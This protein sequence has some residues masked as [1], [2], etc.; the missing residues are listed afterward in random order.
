MES[1]L[2]AISHM[3]KLKGG[4]G[5]L[6][7]NISSVLGIEPGTATAIYSGSKFG[8]V[9]FTKSLAVSLLKLSKTIR[10]YNLMIIS[11]T[12]TINKML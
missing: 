7:V 10:N 8:V 4:K 12:F 11:T 1:T 3:N 9:G 5:G 2:T 6:I